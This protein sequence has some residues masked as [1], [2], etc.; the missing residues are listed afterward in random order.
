MRAASPGSISSLKAY[1]RTPT[2][3]GSP[4]VASHIHPSSE[5]PV[6]RN[7][8]VLQGQPLPRIVPLEGRD[9]RMLPAHSPTLLTDPMARRG[10]TSP[11]HSFRPMGQAPVP[12]LRQESSMSSQSS[13]IA[14]SLSSGAS[15]SSSVY[16]PAS[17]LEEGRS[18]RFLP[19]LSP[20]DYKSVRGSAYGDSGGQS[21]YPLLVN[22]SSSAYTLPP[23]LNSPFLSS[24]SSGQQCEFLFHPFCVHGFHIGPLSYPQSC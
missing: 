19:P 22:Q 23:P 13:S 3:Q 1:H 10:R 20:V 17:P 21:M 16:K 12:Y 24:P 8:E 14:S 7:A 6:D 2:A 11:Q 18:R 9:T 4:R 5:S 15:T